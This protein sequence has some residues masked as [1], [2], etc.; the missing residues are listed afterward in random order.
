MWW[1]RQST[2][3]P[4]QKKLK[5]IMRNSFCKKKQVLQMILTWE[6]RLKF[7]Y[8]FI[9]MDYLNG[10]LNEFLIMRTTKFLEIV[11]LI[12]FLEFLRILMFVK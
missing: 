7:H 8:D 6:F 5:K 10:L 2:R 3:G 12:F 1:Y 11:I 9:G 4:I